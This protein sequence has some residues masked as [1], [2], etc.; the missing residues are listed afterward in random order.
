MFRAMLCLAMCVV[1]F[2]PE[3][4]ADDLP[5]RKP[6]LW[7]MTM[8]L[9]RT[10]PHIVRYCLDTATDAEMRRFG[11][12]QTVNRCSRHD[13]QRSGNTVT[14]EAVCN[15]GLSEVTTHSVT[16]F[17]DDTGY[18]TV[19]SSHFEPPMRVGLADSKTTQ[20]AKWIGPCSADMQPGD[21]IVQGRKMRMP[22]TS[23]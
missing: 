12:A 5:A 2:A 13:V 6:G 18:S 17:L 10:P 20:E 9:G 16:T 1:A 23:Q 14:I 4:G 7:E 8:T 19:A 15:S 22:T 11:E 21:M 3:A